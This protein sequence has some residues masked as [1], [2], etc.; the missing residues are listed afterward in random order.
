MGTGILLFLVR[1]PNLSLVTGVCSGACVQP[2][3]IHVVAL[4]THTPRSLQSENSSCMAVGSSTAPDK[5]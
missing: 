2:Y 1:I 3:I 4:V 5:V